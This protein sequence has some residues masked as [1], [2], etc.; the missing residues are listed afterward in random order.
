MHSPEGLSRRRTRLSA[1]AE[2]LAHFAN[3]LLTTLEIHNRPSSPG[4][5]GKIKKFGG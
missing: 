2:N 5:V 3:V 1:S 4:K